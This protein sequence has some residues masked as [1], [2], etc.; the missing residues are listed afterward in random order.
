MSAEEKYKRLAKHYSVSRGAGVLEQE[1]SDL[2]KAGMSRD[3][4][5]SY[6]YEKTFGASSKPHVR[7][8]KLGFTLG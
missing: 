7:E 5:I 4:A 1:L 6:L 3:E 8:K 2:V